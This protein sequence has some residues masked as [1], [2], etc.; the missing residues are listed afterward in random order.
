VRNRDP[1]RS[2]FFLPKAYHKLHHQVQG[3][4]RFPPTIPLPNTQIEHS[5]STKTDTHTNHA[6]TRTHARARART[7][8][9]TQSLSRSLLLQHAKSRCQEAEGTKWL[10][11]TKTKIASVKRSCSKRSRT[12]QQ[13]G[14]RFVL[15]TNGGDGSPS[16]GKRE[17][18]RRARDSWRDLL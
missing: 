1:I 14:V 18:R 5:Q 10:Q 12:V 9:H 8:T 13:L 16:S 11:I 6:S 17:T 15:E 3:S 4:P 7:H 2:L